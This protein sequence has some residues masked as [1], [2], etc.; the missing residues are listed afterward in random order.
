MSISPIGVRSVWLRHNL[1]PFKDWLKALE[2]RWHRTTSFSQK[3]KS[4]PLRRKMMTVLR[5]R[6][7][8]HHPVYLGSQDTF[9]MGTLKGVGRI[10]QQTFVDTYSMVEFTKLHT[11]KSPLS[12]QLTCL[13]IRYSC[14]LKSSNFQCYECWLTEALSIA[15][16]LMHTT[17]SSIWQSTILTTP[18]PRLDHHRQM[19]FV[20]GYTKLFFKSSIR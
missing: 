10:N 18:K 19:G 14:S 16:D 3:L 4:R 1:V 2:R 6:S 8:P 20:N 17:I 15:G 13:M 9:Y 7:K 11:S 12:P 5:V